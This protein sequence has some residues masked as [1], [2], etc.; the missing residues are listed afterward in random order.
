MR[1]VGKIPGTDDRC[2]VAIGF[3]DG[4][5]RG[6]AALLCETVRI[7]HEKHLIPAVF[8][9]SAEEPYKNMPLLTT[10]AEKERLLLSSGMETIFVVH[11]SEVADLSPETFIRDILHLSVFAEHAV[12]G[13]DFR[14][15][16]GAAGNAE[17]LAASFPTTVVVPVT[18]GGVTVSSTRIR[19]AVA[20]GDTENVRAW[21]G[22]D[23]GFSGTVVHGK[24]LGRTLGFPT[25][26]TFL[27]DG[28]IAPRN[29]VYAATVTV[30]GTEY[31]AVSNIGIRPTVEDGHR[32]NCESHLLHTSGDF[33]GKNADIRL[34]HFIRPEKKFDSVEALA[35]QITEDKKEAFRWMSRSI[36][37]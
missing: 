14:F 8:T 35:A 13:T 16:K 24:A 34:H 4:V 20:A 33:Y 28:L 31:A 37:N 30:E 18:D 7:A 1:I 23:F 27:P 22:R 11:F 29:G 6:H 12:I 17:T 5:H 9:F 26:N 19:E 32:M 25:L 15:G 36:S 21:L 3:F 2:A 10:E